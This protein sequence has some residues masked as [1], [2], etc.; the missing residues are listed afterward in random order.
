MALILV[1]DDQPDV[2]ETVTELLRDMGHQVRGVPDATMALE[3]CSCEPFDLVITDIIM[4]GRFGLDAILE[5]RGKH[6]EMKVVAMSGGG[7]AGPE[8]FL[9]A[10]SRL[11]AHATLAKPFGPTELRDAITGALGDFS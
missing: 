10:A 4:P 2:R 3:A 5:I 11:G 8:G 7:A 1:V 6:P 9:S